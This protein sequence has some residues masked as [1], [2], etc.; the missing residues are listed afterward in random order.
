VAKSVHDAGRAS[1]VAMLEQGPAVWPPV[2]PDRPVRG[3]ARWVHQM[4]TRYHL[5]I[6]NTTTLQGPVPAQVAPA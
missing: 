5:K 1:F 6:H 2:P 3:L 4:I